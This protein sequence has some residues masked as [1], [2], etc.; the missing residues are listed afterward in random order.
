M[1]MTCETR[2]MTDA[3]Y[4]VLPATIVEMLDALTP[5]RDARV[6]SAYG[7]AVIEMNDDGYGD[8]DRVCSTSVADVLVKYG[9][10]RDARD[11]A[12]PV[13]LAE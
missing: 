10:V 13:V 12:G 7:M 11:T 2:N 5:A 9:F 8:F 4:A 1:T 3:D 6:T